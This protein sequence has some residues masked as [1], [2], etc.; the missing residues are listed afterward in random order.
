MTDVIYANITMWML[1]H[2]TQGMFMQHRRIVTVC[3]CILGIIYT[4]AYPVNLPLVLLQYLLT[5]VIVEAYSHRNKVTHYIRAPTITKTPSF[6]FPEPAV[7]E[8]SIVKPPVVPPRKIHPRAF[9]TDIHIIS[10]PE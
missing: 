2:Y 9:N 3:G 6:S 8:P 4:W 5:F 7:D 1:E 10:T